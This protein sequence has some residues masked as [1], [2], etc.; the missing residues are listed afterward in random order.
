VR[1]VRWHRERHP[2]R[3]DQQQRQ[4]DSFGFER[5]RQAL[6]H[7]PG[8]LVVAVDH[9]LAEVRLDVGAVSRQRELLVLRDA[10][11]RMVGARGP[12]DHSLEEVV[13]DAPQREHAGPA[14]DLAR[15]DR[16]AQLGQQSQRL[17]LG[18]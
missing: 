6:H 14:S 13:Q 7:R 15:E 12:V 18:V 2:E 10:R 8:L 5:Q 11:H 17:R 9:A 3:G 16:V 4:T 1:L